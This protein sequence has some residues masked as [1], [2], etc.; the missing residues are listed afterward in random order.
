VG[1]LDPARRVRRRSVN[2]LGYDPIWDSIDTGRFKKSHFQIIRAGG[3]NSIRVNLQPFRH[4]GATPDYRLN[5]ARWKTADWIVTNAL[6]AKLAVILD[7]TNTRPPPSN[8]MFE[9]L[10]EP[11]SKATPELWN[12]YLALRTTSR[13]ANGWSRFTRL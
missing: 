11:N 13:G 1:I 12:Q 4:M 7:S 10:N 2:V 6:A 3:F 5:D 9:I 8:V